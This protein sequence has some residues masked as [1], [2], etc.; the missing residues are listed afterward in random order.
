[1]NFKKKKEGENNFIKRLDIKEFKEPIKFI[2]Q[3]DNNI[4]AISDKI[5]NIKII[6][7]NESMVNYSIIQEIKPNREKSIYSMIYLPILS[8]HNNR[9]HFCMANDYYIFFY[10]SNKLPN[11]LM[12]YKDEYHGSIQ[13]ISKEQP[14]SIIQGLNNISKEYN[15]NNNNSNNKPVKFD[16]IETIQLNTLANSLVEINE[17]YIAAVCTNSNSIKFFDVNNKFEEKISIN[18]I[19]TCGGSYIMN[20]VDNGNILIVGTTKGFCL[21][22]TK[23]LEILKKFNKNMKII[24]L[25]VIYDNTIICC[26]IIEGNEKKILQVKYLPEKSDIKINDSNNKEKDEVWDLKC[27]GNNIYF[28]SNTD[29]II[30][31]N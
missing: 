21:I 5:S 14:T 28:I 9:H 23:T 19:N 18:D 10:K 3:I 8:F 17:K 27:F 16:L 1:M 12:I 2:C 31:K 11:N 15:Q 6:K 4:I 29:L 13:D 30:S 22:S 7:L 26:A 25:G 20:L 24:S